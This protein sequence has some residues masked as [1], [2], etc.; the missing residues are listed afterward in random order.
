MQD[1]DLLDLLRRDPSAGMKQLMEQY[2]GLVHS[3]VRGKLHTPPFSGEDIEDCTADVFLEFYGGMGRVDLTKGSIRGWLCT[4]AR[5]RAV[6]RLRMRYAAPELIPLGEAAHLA[7]GESPEGELIRRE[8]REH[9]LKALQGL[10]AV[11]REILF[12]KYYLSQPS[13]E[14]AQRM[15]QTVS[16]VDTRAHRAIQKVRKRMEETWDG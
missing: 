12:R 1:A 14:I 8:E 2:A 6:D 10:D 11:D 4:I 7:E 3:V 13:R 5:N 15:G 9:L 16:N